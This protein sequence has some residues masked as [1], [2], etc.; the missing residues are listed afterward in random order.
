MRLVTSR[1]LSEM[2]NVSSG[3]TDDC[4][5]EITADFSFIAASPIMT[6]I[7]AWAEVVAKSDIPILI[8]GEQGSGKELTARLIHKL[9][10]RS[11][12]PFIKVN[13]A[14][15]P[16]DFLRGELFGYAAGGF[17]N[18]K[19]HPGKFERCEK[20]TILL[21]GIT[22]MPHRLQVELL[23]VLE[24]QQF[25]RV[26]EDD[27][28]QADVR[29]LA[30]V[31]T[32]VDNIWAETKLHESVYY[33]LSACM[34]QIPPLRHRRGEIPLLLDH[35]MQRSARRSALSP[36]TF[37]AEM[38]ESC[39]NYPWPGNLLELEKFVMRYLIAAT[40]GPA[41]PF[42]RHEDSQSK[43]VPPEGT[44]RVVEFGFSSVGSKSLLQNVRGEAERSAIASV[45]EQT[46]WNRRA[47]A[48]LLRI[49]YRTLLYK[50]EQYSMND[51]KCS[52]PLRRSS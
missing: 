52:S 22:E 7:R 28:V 9:S 29:I 20:G 21:D 31:D 37:S 39:Q 44:P 15:L 19:A 6:R 36:R 14:A 32:N 41:I 50:I 40:D 5:E 34:V 13:C 45:L 51:P 26:G 47:A 3:Y 10:P 33:N 1:D 38:L 18:D 8:L 48:R 27:A 30:S 23:R 24:K 42:D 49:S 2:H 35:F 25:F 11:V 16:E 4:M 12:H 46:C 43:I 17:A